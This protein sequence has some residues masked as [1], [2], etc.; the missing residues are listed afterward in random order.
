MNLT[1]LKSLIREVIEHVF[2]ESKYS[3]VMNTMTGQ[4][5]KIQTVGLITAENPMG[6]KL[7]NSQNQFL[8][9]KLK[10]F[11]STHKISY[12]RIHYLWLI[13][14]PTKFF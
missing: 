11:L 5:P 14:I 4:R 7:S 12:Y 13:E 1:V 8:N 2:D 9:K 10:E 6:S 3:K